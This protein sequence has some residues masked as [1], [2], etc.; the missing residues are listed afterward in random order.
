[1]TKKV[2]CFILVSLMLFSFTS[3]AGK[4]TDKQ[5]VLPIDAE[6]KYLDPQIVSEAGA[7]NIIANCFDNLFVYDE[8]GDIVPS[9]CEKYEVSDDGLRYTFYL[10]K[11]GRWRVTSAAKKTIEKFYENKK[12]YD[13][14][15]DFDLRV[16]ADD[17]VF[18]LRRALQPETK[19]PYAPG[20]MNIK[21]AAEVNKGKFKS[22][23]LG[24]AAKDDYT[25]V[26]KLQKK[27]SDF[28]SVL[29][30]PAAAPCNEEFF[31]ITKGHYGLSTDY[32]IY[33]GPFYISNWAEK[34]AITA[35]R[36][37][38]YRAT[39]EEIKKGE[40]SAA[41]IVFP[42]SLYFSFNNEQNTRADKIKNGTYAVAPLTKQQSEE[43]INSKKYGLKAFNS[44]VTSFV[45]N[46]N[47]EILAE[48]DIRK[49]IS[50]VL[51][52]SIFTEN[53]G[54]TSAKGV[55]PEACVSEGT[56]YRDKTS[57]VTLKKGSKDEALNMY[58]SV[59]DKLQKND[60]EFVIICEEENE[61]FVRNAMQNWQSVF[62]AS[63]SVS[64]ESV[65]RNTLQSRVQSGE[66]QIA[67]CD[68]TY[69]DVTAQN[70]L[71]R[72]KSDSRDNLINLKSKYYDN[73]IENISRA[74]DGKQKLAALKEAERFL[75]NTAVM[76]PVS[77]S[78]V[79]YG[80]GKGV[81][82]IVFNP[83]GEVQYFKN[84]IIR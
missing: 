31:E 16:T 44:S 68:V 3:C 33:N 49:A 9:A 5:I 42:S 36:N 56:S 64:V 40:V 2:L 51:D 26:I 79:Y 19:C 13:F 50:Y 39:A 83:T 48:K 70:A 1:M 73:L 55:L 11:D 43:F 72:Y 47:D 20:F 74:T 32:L 27:D 14:S 59:L 61:T 45:F 34:T 69:T 4:E 38:Y 82:G 22:N 81:E 78:S 53:N 76:I 29:T 37:E 24:V 46:L 12:D 63:F 84:A 8:K 28:I 52:E 54:G 75:V 25:L 60:A 77:E 41:D 15:R 23:R 35:R 62:G 66:Y 58:K 6:P 65:D 80:T 30:S 71:A 7:K 67:F 57:S 10:R 21:N 18:A 17:F